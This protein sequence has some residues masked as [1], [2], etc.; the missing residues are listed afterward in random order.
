MPAYFVA[1]NRHRLPALITAMLYLTLLP[2]AAYYD[3]TRSISPSAATTPS[4]TYMEQDIVATAL[5]ARSSVLPGRHV[6]DDELLYTTKP[7]RRRTSAPVCFVATV[8][9][10]EKREQYEVCSAMGGAQTN[11]SWPSD[12]LKKKSMVQAEAYAIL[13][14]IGSMNG[15]GMGFRLAREG[16]WA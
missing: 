2:L 5:S 15:E 1:G 12:L 11:A 6:R 13:S 14:S 16:R 7:S 4:H 3:P 9:N 8:A 10:Q